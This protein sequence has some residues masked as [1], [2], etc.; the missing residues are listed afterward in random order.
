[1]SVA[2]IAQRLKYFYFGPGMI[3]LFEK[4]EMKK[5]LI[6]AGIEKAIIK[7]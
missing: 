3:P 5:N 4:K 6:F 1:M 2:Q 7:D